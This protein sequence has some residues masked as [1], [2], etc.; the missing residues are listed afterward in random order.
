MFPGRMRS[1]ALGAK[2]CFLC[3]LSVCPSVHME[4]YSGLRPVEADL[5]NAGSLFVLRLQ[6]HQQSPP[7]GS[8]QP[9]L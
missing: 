1:T 4:A 8:G 3:L 6:G 9:A 7:P 2:K 5:G